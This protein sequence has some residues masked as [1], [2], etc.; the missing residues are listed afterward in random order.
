MLPG[1]PPSLGPLEIWKRI[2][3]LYRNNSKNAIYN[4]GGVCICVRSE[5]RYFDVKFAD[6]V[7][8]WCKKWLYVKDE[9][10]GSQEYGLS[11]FN[12]SEDIQRRKS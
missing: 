3:Y 2:F 12:A 1:H 5:A 7:Q 10:L 6:S 4:I 8:G 11:P 9:S